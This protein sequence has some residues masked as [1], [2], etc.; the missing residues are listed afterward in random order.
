MIEQETTESRRLPPKAYAAGSLVMFAQGL[1]A[2][3]LNSYMVDIGASLSEIGAFRSVGNMAPTVMQPVWGSV[4]DK[5]GHT[6]AFVAFGTASGL[7]AVFLFLFAASPLDMI[8]LYGIQSILLSIQIPTWLSLVGSLIDEDNRGHELGRLGVTTNIMS[9]L[10]TLFAGF[11]AGFPGFG[12]YLRSNLGWLGL[13]IFPSVETWKQIYYLPFYLAAI[14]GIFASIVSI[15]IQTTKESSARPREFPPVLRLL[16]RPGDFRRFCFVSVFFSF[17]MSMA[18]PFWIIV[19]RQWLDNTLLEIA[20]ASAIMTLTTVIFTMP[21]GRL[22]DRVGRKP[23]IFLGRVTLF[24]VPIMYAFASTTIIIYFANAIAGFC[25]AASANASTA[26]I[27][28]IAPSEERGSHL[29]VYNTFTGI[30]MLV[31]SLLAGIIGDF[32]AVGL[33][34]YLAVFAM[35]LVS[36]GLRFIS[37]F[38]YLLLDE[39]REYSSDFWTEIRGFILGRHADRGL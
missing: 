5:T 27:Y 24:I 23:L 34:N 1:Y 7:F 21:F 6:K 20:I 29:S 36:G 38:F 19:Q 31:G 33:G 16:S 28:D 15:R 25:V 14:T 32:V 10:A 35:L 26:Y 22:S 11:I 30:V 3:F 18:W 37:S 39:P 12:A 17:S 4:S 8:I 13:I 2:P 9:L